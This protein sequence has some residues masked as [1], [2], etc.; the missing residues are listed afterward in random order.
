M[1]TMLSPRMAKNLWRLLGLRRARYAI[2]QHDL[3]CE[4]LAVN[5][6]PDD[7]GPTL[8]EA[9][10]N[11]KHER[12]ILRTAL[13]DAQEMI[14]AVGTEDPDDVGPMADVEKLS[15]KI[16]AALHCGEA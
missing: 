16:T 10:Q 4:D 2:G 1:E 6:G 5:N 3:A 9:I 8:H 7:A 13:E 14:Q 12:D 15:G 11:L